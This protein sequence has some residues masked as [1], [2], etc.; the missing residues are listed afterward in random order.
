[1]LLKLSDGIH[2]SPRRRQV[3]HLENVSAIYFDRDSLF[4]VKQ[5]RLTWVVRCHLQG[6]SHHCQQEV[7]QRSP[8][9]YCKG[10]EGQLH[11][12]WRLLQVLQPERLQGVTL[13]LEGMFNTVR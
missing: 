4:S 5:M 6:E 2:S 7:N 1:M 3:K 10:R 11:F 13:F 9:R 8:K 12:L